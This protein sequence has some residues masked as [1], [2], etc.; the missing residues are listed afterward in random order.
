MFHL[1]KL[2]PV[3]LSQHT[4]NVYLRVTATGEF[5]PPIFEQEDEAG[6]R[7]LLEGLEPEQVRCEPALA[8]AADSLGLEVE[9]PP[10]EV[11]SARAAIAIFMAWEQ[12]GVAGLGAD[13]ALLFLQAATE[14]WEARPW[15]HWDD[16][17]PFHVTI[18]GPLNRTYEGSIFGGGEEGGEG[19]A[20]Y[21]Q[22]GAL[23]LLMDLQGRGQGNAASSLPAIGVTLDNRPDYAVA[24]LAAAGRVPRLPLPLKTGPSGILVPSTVE[25]LVLVAT[26][27]AVARLA[28]TR[29][30]ALSTVVAGDAQMAV[31]VLAPPPRLRN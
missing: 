6:V 29:R 1:L 8:E 15:S 3:Q 26:L 13:K 23:K 7:A 2:G 12:R 20:L 4:T 11:L 9:S 24:A 10:Q 30:E 21:E 25:A 14:F 5:A 22:T 16:S 31:R 28:P 19:L 27:R 17:Q 18:S